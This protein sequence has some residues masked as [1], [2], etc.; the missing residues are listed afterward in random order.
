[1]NT[2]SRLLQQQVPFDKDG[3]G[4]DGGRPSRLDPEV[5][6][7]KHDD[8]KDAVRVLSRKLNEVEAD[9]A[10]L[11]EERRTLRKQL[12]SD[13]DV[14]L[15][16]E[17][18][19]ALHEIGVLTDDNTVQHDDVQ[20]R[21]EAGREA[22]QKL[23]SIERNKHMETVASAAGVQLGALRL[24][25]K[26]H[27]DD[28]EYQIQGDGENASV[29]VKTDDGVQDFDQFADDHFSD[30]KTALYADPESG[31]DDDEGQEASTP[32]SKQ[33]P[34]TQA[35]DGTRPSGKSKEKTTKTRNYRFQKKGDV[36]W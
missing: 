33:A 30:V 7:A 2:F 23:Q 34:S 18:A 1:M 5:L 27:D 19:S 11:R 14:V 20:Q 21:L 24:A 13:D 15:S 31:S 16:A 29:V 4:G 17:E 10:S 8:A 25:T 3:G 9:N 35:G 28:V 32:G 12:P 22:Q 6:L 26:A 36:E